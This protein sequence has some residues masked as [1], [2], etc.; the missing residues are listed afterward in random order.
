V[1]GTPRDYRDAHPTTPVLVVEVAES[2]LAFDRQHKGGLYARA[3][4]ADYWIVNLVNRVLEVYREPAAIPSTPHG[5]QYR[6][7]QTLAPAAIVSPLAVPSATIR[8][9]DLLP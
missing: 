4:V 7:A 8:V 5:W 1:R 3:G 6:G 2:S 9:G